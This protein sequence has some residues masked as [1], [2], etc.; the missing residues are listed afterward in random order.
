MKMGG[1][2]NERKKLR[3]LSKYQEGNTVNVCIT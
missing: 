1:K 2:K 3:T